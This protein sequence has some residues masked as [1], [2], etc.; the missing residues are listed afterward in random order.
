MSKV[1]TF[2]EMLSFLRHSTLNTVVVEG[3]DDV[4]IFRWIE[5][6]LNKDITGTQ[7]SIFPCGCRNTLLQLFSRRDE[8]GDNV[9]FVADLDSY[10]YG[11]VPVEYHDVI[12]TQG[13]SIENDLYQGRDI[14][15]KFFDEEDNSLFSRYLKAFIEYYAGEVEKYTAGESYEL[16]RSPQQVL[17][18]SAFCVKQEFKPDIQPNCQT[19][20]NLLS[21]YDLLVRGHSLFQLVSLVVGRKGRLSHPNLDSIYEMVYKVFSS[22]CI[23]KMKLAIKAAFTL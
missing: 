15:K 20:N 7:I 22:Q 17:D 11:T 19:V 18:L 13:Y 10:V 16:K 14:E 23:Q 21:N 3:K 12:F 9:I 4:K 6:D 2:E 5:S 1:L 8:I